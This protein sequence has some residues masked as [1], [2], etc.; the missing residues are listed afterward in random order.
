MKR[1]YRCQTNSRI[2]GV[3]EGLGEYFDMDPVIF[4]IG[5]VVLFFVGGAGLLLY[6][7]MG[8]CMPKK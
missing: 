3:C 6:L 8:F 1:L 5:F 7:I 4:R 2:M